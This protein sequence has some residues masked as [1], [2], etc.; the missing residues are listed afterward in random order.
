MSDRTLINA[1]LGFEARFVF[2]DTP[3]ALDERLAA[4]RRQGWMEWFP[5][6]GDDGRP[7]VAMF[8]GRAAVGG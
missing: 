4:L 5:G 3:E 1:A 8:R 2:A 7:G 6:V